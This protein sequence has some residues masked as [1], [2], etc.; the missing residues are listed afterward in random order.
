MTG[1]KQCWNAF[2]C[3]IHM[4]SPTEDGSMSHAA[5]WLYFLNQEY[6]D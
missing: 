4:F 3:W 6:W 1:I 5:F 2:D